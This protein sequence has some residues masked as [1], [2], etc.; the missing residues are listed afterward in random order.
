M[1][2]VQLHDNREYSGDLREG[3]SFYGVERFCCLLALDLSLSTMA[4]ARSNLV[5]L[6]SDAV[7]YRIGHR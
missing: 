2:S 4:F 6:L 5:K 7:P 3:G 1:S